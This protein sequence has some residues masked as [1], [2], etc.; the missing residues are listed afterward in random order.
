[1]SSGCCISSHRCAT[2]ALG[3]APHARGTLAL[4]TWLG[5]R[6]A[7]AAKLTCLGRKHEEEDGN[8]CEE[9]DGNKC[10]EEDGN[11]CEEEDGNKCEEEDGTKCEE[12]DYERCAVRV[13]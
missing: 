4:Q 12:E 7:I 11:K 6:D 9:E 2:T 5:C 3:H 1:M 10:E 13:T 8:K